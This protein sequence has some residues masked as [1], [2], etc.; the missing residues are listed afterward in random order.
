VDRIFLESPGC[1]QSFDTSYINFKAIAE[2]RLFHFGYPPLLRQFY[3]HKGSQLVEMFREVK[4]LGVITSM[5][6]SLPDKE[7]ESGKI[8]WLEI[9][10]RALPFTD[11][12]TPSLEEALQ[13]VIPSKYDEIQ[14]AASNN[15]EV[16]DLIPMATIR[17]VGKCI[18]DAGTKIVLIKAGHRGVYLQ[19]GD[20]RSINEDYGFN[21][22]QEQWN[23]RELWCQAYSVDPS[24]IKNASGAG[25]VAIAAFISSILDG[26]SP[27]LSLRYAAMAGRDK[28]YCSNIYNDLPDGQKVWDEIRSE[29]NELVDLKGLKNNNGVDLNN[30]A[31]KRKRLKTS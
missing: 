24:R 29:T 19:T 1:S 25:D 23:F 18:I 20:I 13:I 27:E 2:S 21:L 22:P 15:E 9:M 26:E 3:L 4:R 14:S 6:F 28:L 17:E 31:R 12:F 8:D 11:I 7:S 30:S 5:D 10:K 16:I